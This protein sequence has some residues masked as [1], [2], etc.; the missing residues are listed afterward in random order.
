MNDFIQLNSNIYCITIEYKD[1]FTSV[2]VIK[3]KDGV[4]LFDSASYDSDID[5]VVVPILKKLDLEKDLKYVFISHAHVD[6]WGGLKRL[7][8]YYPDITI[9]SRKDDIEELY[10]GYKVVKPEENQIFLDVLK[11]I[12]IVG[13]T[14]DSAGI[15]D[16]RDNTLLSGDSLQMYGIFGSGKWCA[17]VRFPAQHLK[18]VEKLRNIKIERIFTA[19]NYHPMEKRF[20]QGEEEVKIALDSSIAPLMDIKALILKNP[21]LNDKEICALFNNNENLPTLGDHVVTAV[22]EQLFY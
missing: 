3:T 6:H 18:D 12:P 15:L 5:D 19:H 13:H 8:K 11:V 22:R 9:I 7:L 2:Y 21:T 16:M 20:C 4:M 14:L 10:S 17:N 1:I